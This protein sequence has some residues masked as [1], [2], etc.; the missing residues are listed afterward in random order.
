MSAAL[1]ACMYLD[2]SGSQAGMNEPYT[3]PRKI[4]LCLSRLVR[5]YLAPTS[6]TH[7]PYI[8]LSFMKFIN[9][10]GQAGYSVYKYVPYGPVIEVLPYLSRRAKENSA[11]LQK[12]EKEKRLLLRE[13]WRRIVAGQI[14]YKPKGNYTP[15]GAQVQ[16]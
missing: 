2:L 3:H 6:Q 16:K 15:V 1:F 14:F 9:S 5:G 12:L 4:P 10:T 7:A 8:T 13:L 11:I